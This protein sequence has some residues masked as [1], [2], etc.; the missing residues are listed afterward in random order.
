MQ[1]LLLASNNQHKLDEVRAILSGVAVEV[2]SP[3][4]L[5]LHLEVAETGQTY[6]ENAALKALAFAKASGLP[7]LAD[8]SGLEVDLL[9]GAPGVHSHRLLADP[10]ATDKDR[11][12]H[13]LSLLERF[14]RPWKA[15]FISH[16]ILAH[17]DIIV[18]D[19]RGICPG[20]IIPEARGERGFGYDPI[21]QLEGGNLTMAEL[22]DAEKNQVSH[23]ARALQGL[24]PQLK[25]Y[26]EIL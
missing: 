13:L 7:T 21:F 19:Y 15:R 3:A 18:A 17:Q 5:G 2:L 10:A 14:P 12:L 22:S 6:F 9:D 24:I 4:D 23:R 25:A 1:Q 16:V 26:I 11:Y 8:D 20:E